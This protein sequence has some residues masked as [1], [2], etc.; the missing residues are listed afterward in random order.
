MPNNYENE[1]TQ[2]V[3]EI[4]EVPVEKLKPDADFFT[5]LGVDSLKAIE[6]VAAFEKKYR[7]IIPEQDIPKI[8][9]IK[10]I[11]DYTKNLEKKSK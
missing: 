11:L 3:S 4:I 9:T 8:R 2:M 5:D 1:I 10:Q 6:I 7:Q